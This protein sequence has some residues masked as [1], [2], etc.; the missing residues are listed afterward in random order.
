MGNSNLTRYRNALAGLIVA[1]LCGTV[2][3]AAD[4][5]APSVPTGLTASVMGTTVIYLAWQASNDNVAV[6]SYEVFRDGSLLGNV[7]SNGAGINGLSP[8]TTYTFRVSA[9]DAAGNCSAQS[10]AA[11]ASTL[12]ADTR[13]PSVPTGLVAT[14]TSASQIGLAWNA[15]TDNLGVTGYKVF[16]GAAQLGTA[17]STNWTVIQLDAGTTY[18]FTVSACDA[19]GNCSEQSASASATTTGAPPSSATCSGA[20]PPADQQM[21]SCPGGQIG[22]IFQERTYSCVGTTWT[23][24][25][26]RT[27][28]NTCT[29]LV[30]SI[31]TSYQGMWW[32]GLQENGWGLTITQHQDALFLAWYIYDSAGN[33]HWIVMPN[34][35]WN[36]SH[37]SFAGELYMPTGSWY[38]N[39]DTAHFDAGASVGIG[40][41]NFTSGSTAELS[42]TVGSV[43]GFKSISRL[44]FG[45]VNTAPITDYTDMWW[46][47]TAQD[48]WGVVL[49]QQYHNI[50]AA[51]YTYDSSGQTTWFVMPD[52]AWSN[53]TYSGPLYSTKGTPV[54]GGTY[55][56]AELV[57]T[58]AG[59]LS[60]TFT[61]AND[62]TM[63]YTVNGLTQTKLITRLP[64]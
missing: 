38:G 33:P 52:G 19:A 34:G 27:A 29:S 39:Y 63:T 24:G 61:D 30:N 36:N 42:Y 25:A 4:T 12:A 37:T 10:G 16:Q 26:Y 2:A 48:G 28:A 8:G 5:Q 53:N 62:A 17:S 6:T 64:F 51:W 55:N 3:A 23:P 45:A 9:C 43:F 22:A 44:A 21:L 13:A 60:I 18:S 1:G 58:P 31:P 20:Q 40:S 50:F 14:A 46:G 7:A 41:I 49:T 57:V 47:G 11:S 35:E 32:A 15:S 59:T 54:I 56:A